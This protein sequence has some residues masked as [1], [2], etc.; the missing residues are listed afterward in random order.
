MRESM[1]E[2]REKGFRSYEVATI[3]APMWTLLILD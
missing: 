1:E 3:S 2:M